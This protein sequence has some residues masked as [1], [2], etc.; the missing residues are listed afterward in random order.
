MDPW[1]IDKKMIGRNV[2]P[3]A[4]L[5]FDRAF[6]AVEKHKDTEKLCMSNTLILLKILL[7]LGADY[8]VKLG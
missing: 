3:Y 7:S 1:T 2:V 8:L 5:S 4:R 6:A